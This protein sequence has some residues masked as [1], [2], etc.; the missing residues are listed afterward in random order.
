MAIFQYEYRQSP[1]HELHPLTKVTILVTFSLLT[2]YFQD[3]RFKLPFFITLLILAVISKLP[4]RDY[5]GFLCFVVISIMLAWSYQILF[6]VDPDMFR[7]YDYNFVSTTIFELLPEGTPILGRVALTYGGL[8]WWISLPLTAI[9]VV[10]T[11]AIY[12]YST[13]LSDTLYMLHQ[14]RVPFPVIYIASVALRFVPELLQKLNTI[15]TAQQLRGW[16]GK[17][18]NPIKAVRLYLPLLVPIVRHIIKATDTMTLSSTNRGFGLNRVASLRQLDFKPTDYAI[19]TVSILFFAAS[20]VAI[21]RFH[22]GN[23]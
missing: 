21:F 23:M 12:I 20:M 6:V 7:V 5:V 8:L 10:L 4:I 19:M 18:R 1:I 11:V 3:P 14:L 9:C 13:S 16:S 2:S 22:L 17:T 15:R